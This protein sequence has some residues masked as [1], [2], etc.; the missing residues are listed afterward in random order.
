MS[1]DLK[2]TYREAVR[3]GDPRRDA[4]ATSASS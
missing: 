2:M 1:A 4:R 3:D